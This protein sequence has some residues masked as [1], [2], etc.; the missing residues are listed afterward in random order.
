MTCIARPVAFFLI[1]VLTSVM[2]VFGMS[3]LLTSVMAVIL[4][5]LILAVLIIRVAALTRSRRAA[6]GACTTC[7]HPC[8]GRPVVFIDET[9][10]A[11]TPPCWPDAPM[12]SPAQE[13]LSRLA[14]AGRR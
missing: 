6:S 12:T 3:G 7:R 9:S 8:Q 11:L 14:A 13:K 1:I 10:L 2:A 4:S 5:A